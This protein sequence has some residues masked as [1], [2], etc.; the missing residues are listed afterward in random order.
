MSIGVANETLAGLRRCAVQGRDAEIHLLGHGEPLLLLHGGWAGARAHWQ[1]VWQKLAETFLVIA[2]ELPGVVEGDPLGTFVDYSAW[3]A[4]VLSTLGTSPVIC[5]GNSLGAI[6]GWCLA[7]QAPERVRKLVLVDGGLLAHDLVSRALLALPGGVA[8]LRQLA[9]YNAFGPST[10]RRAFADPSRAPAELVA[11]LRLPS[12]AQFE[13]MFS[14]FLRG[15]NGIGVPQVPVL[16][17]WGGQDR[18]IGWTTKT[19]K[20]LARRIPGAILHVFDDAG[21]LPQV[22]QPEQFVEVLRSFADG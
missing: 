22:E 11:A 14:L 10:L 4:E 16:V 7:C 13:L 15:A 17:A 8:I 12:K 6:I 2:P 9:R 3:V 19:G 5:V 20:R 21:H 1:P 18:L